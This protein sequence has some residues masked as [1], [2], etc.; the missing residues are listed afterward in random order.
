M[1]RA[2]SECGV[3]AE[4]ACLNIRYQR[5]IW[6]VCE[7]M[8]SGHEVDQARPPSDGSVASSWTMAD[9]VALCSDNAVRRP[10]GMQVIEH[11]SALSRPMSVLCL[12]ISV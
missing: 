5:G 1:S 11:G 2:K 12:M 4:T 6:E 10:V 8:G 3:T 9:D 7:E